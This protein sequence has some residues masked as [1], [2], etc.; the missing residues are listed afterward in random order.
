MWHEQSLLPA[1]RTIVVLLSVAVAGSALA[2]TAYTPAAWR[3][4]GFSD[5]FGFVLSML[6]EAGQLRQTWI[7]V[8]AES[9]FRVFS[10]LCTVDDYSFESAGWLMLS[11]ALVVAMAWLVVRLDAYFVCVS[12][13]AGRANYCRQQRMRGGTPAGTSVL[14][15]LP[16]VPW[17]A[18][19][20]PLAWRQVIGA[21]RHST[22]LFLALAGP[23]LLAC[24]PMVLHQNAIVGIAEVLGVLALYTFV[25]LPAAFK[26]DF[27]RDFE[28][29][30]TLKTLPIRPVA[31]AIGQI[32]TP[33][34]L[35][36]VFQSAVL[37]VSVLIQPVDTDV[38]V[39]SFLLLLLL[40]VFVFAADNLIYLLYPYRFDQEGLENLHSD[41][42]DIHRKG[43]AF[44]PCRRSHNRLGGNGVR[45]RPVCHQT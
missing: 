7:G 33:T 35:A 44:R 4:T 45:A 27:R 29:F 15:R 5:T 41:N 24:L 11:T 43:R 14:I 37:L 19:V 42:V 32:A 3:E 17:C 21:P 9:P 12:S 20:G 18:G 31:M 39:A 6:H 40:N 2:S 1:F 13:H 30:A 23:G 36:S 25:L 8:L 34:V 16:R 22:G 28:R 26:F 10:H 38:L